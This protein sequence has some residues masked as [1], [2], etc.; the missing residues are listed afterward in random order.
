MN[1]FEMWIKI[2]YAVV[3]ALV[4]GIP[5]LLSLIATIKRFHNA[6]KDALDATDEAGKLQA[7]AE[8]AEAKLD[9]INY[10]KQL[11]TTAESTFD[12]VNKIM[13]QRGESAGPIK[14]EV[15][16]AKLQSYATENG[17][18][19]DEAE[20]SNEVDNI[21]KLTKEVNSCN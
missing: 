14:K 10:A 18:D 17:Y 5:L 4:S 11:I 2:I 7:D 21:V 19:F 1:N 8:A 13:K 20:W 6:K 12:T 15:V 3:G 16:M 9:L